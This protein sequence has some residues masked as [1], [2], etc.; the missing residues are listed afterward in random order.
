MFSPNKSISKEQLGDH[1]VIGVKREPFSTAFVHS[2]RNRMIVLSIILLQLVFFLL[3]GFVLGAITL[4]H[5]QDMNMKDYVSEY[6]YYWG[7]RR[8]LRMLLAFVLDQGKREV[9]PIHTFI[10]ALL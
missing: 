1:I 2:T 8:F 6:F 10:F 4:S 7:L 3:I 5:Q 9:K